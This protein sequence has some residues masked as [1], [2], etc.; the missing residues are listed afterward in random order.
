MPN[1]KLDPAQIDRIKQLRIDR[2]WAIENP[3]WLIAASKILKPDYPDWDTAEKFAISI[4]PWKN[5][6]DGKAIRAAT[7]KA[8]CQILA[9]DWQ[10][11]VA[12][13][14]GI[15][16]ANCDWGE[17]PDT[18]MFVSRS[19][20]ITT[21]DRWIVTE[22]TRLV[23]VLGIGGI[24]KTSLVTKL[25]QNIA[26]RFEYVIWR[27]LRE[28]PPVDRII[29]DCIKLFSQHQAIDLPQTLGEQIALLIDRLRNARC[30]MILDNA[31]AILQ[32]GALVGNYQP[33]STGY[34]ELFR[35]I[36]E[37][38]HQ[39]CLVVTSREQFREIRRLQGESSPVRAMQLMGLQDAAKILVP[40]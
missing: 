17:A 18:A 21:L 9:L 37:S 6:L 40:S 15:S 32:S 14:A 3:Q 12:K 25:A 39:S 10:A 7:F 27:S 36:G 11:V 4:H 26:D 19:I 16:T 34:G 28:A 8:F 2:G 35:R 22:R 38:P 20:E 31:E 29:A 23:T 13:T 1:L 24:G 30:L 33:R 5:F